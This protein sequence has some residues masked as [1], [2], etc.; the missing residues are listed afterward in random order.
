MRDEVAV[1]QVN[2]IEVGSMP[3]SQYE[4]IV[5]SVKRDWRTRVAS[6]FSYVGFVWR[7]VIRLCSYFV[8]SF[9]VIIALFMLYSSFHSVETTQFITEL[10]NTPSERIAEAIRSITNICVILTS[11]ACALSIFIK[12]IPVFVSASENGINKKIREVMEVPA[13]GRVSVIFKKDGTYC[14]R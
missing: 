14:V 12:G 9:A 7:I 3:L 8:Q 13:E 4:D 1:I 11:I 6:V 5:E 2:N 10:R